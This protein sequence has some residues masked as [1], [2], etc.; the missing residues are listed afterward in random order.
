MA[1]EILAQLGLKI[2]PFPI[3]TS[4][5]A[6]FFTPHTKMIFTELLYGIRNRQ[7][8]MVLVGEVGMGKTSLCLQLLAQLEHQNTPF[9]W[10]IY[11]MFNK[12][13]L[14]QAIAKDFGLKPK[15]NFFQ[16]YEQL[17]DYFLTLY[18]NKRNC[19]II[20][21]E[22]HNLNF[23]CLESLRMLSNLEHK[24]N[25]LVQIL[26]IGQPEL[27]VILNQP[28]LR[29]LR[30]R[31]SIFTEL[32]PLNSQ[33]LFEYILFKL[34]YANAGIQIDYKTVQYIWELTKGNLRL[35]NIIMEKSLY[36][37]IISEKKVITKK[38]I[39]MALKDIL[40]YQIDIRNNYIQRQNRI[41]L[42]YASIIMASIIFLFFFTIFKIG[43]RNIYNIF[44]N[45][46][47]YISIQGNNKYSTFQHMDMD[48]QHN[49]DK[50]KKPYEDYSKKECLLEIKSFLTPW[51][52][53]FLDKT[54]LQSIQKKDLNIFK[55]SFNL[56]KKLILLTLNRDLPK[57]KKSW[58]FFPWKKYTKKNP[59]WIVL[60]KPEIKLN[61]P[62]NKQKTIYCIQLILARLGYLEKNNLTRKLDNKM[63]N[64]IKKFQQ[65]YNLTVTG[66]LNTKTIF[67]LENKGLPTS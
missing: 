17:K 3:A 2:N 12:L 27:Q 58:T 67:W 45:L 59:K 11:T 39:K 42:R 13:E 47:S 36:A 19:V 53:D 44:N 46:S 1:N 41:Y 25:K 23:Q 66:E 30:S 63:Q 28:Q 54:L 26:L 10:I 16:I 50:F 49:I 22:A 62:T 20:I 24:G 64:A 56:N 5:E 14:F 35:T 15:T 40:P 65:D 55:K 4:Q 32:K 57:K 43:I 29:Q 8:F 51:K 61:S 34:N 52:L 9:S 6:Y 7:G 21:D 31:I 38:I 60:W 48:K 18:K 33:E 37:L